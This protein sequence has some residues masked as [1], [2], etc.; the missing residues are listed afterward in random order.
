MNN[1]INILIVAAVLWYFFI[2]DSFMISDLFEPTDVTSYDCA[3]LANYFEGRNLQ[4]VFGGSFKVLE[5]TNVQKI[6]RTDDRLRCHGTVLLSNGDKR[7]MS[8]QVYTS[9]KDRTLYE[10]RPI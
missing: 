6:S 7:R 2:N 1:L 10:I 3:K 9:E 8:L 4:N 5:I